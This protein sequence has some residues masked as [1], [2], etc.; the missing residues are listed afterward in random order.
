MSYFVFLYSNKYE[1]CMRHVVTKILNIFNNVTCARKI[2][3]EMII[4]ILY[5]KRIKPLVNYY[6]H[7]QLLEVEDGRK[8][9]QIG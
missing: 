3:S 2:I 1:F 7:V 9:I 8:D 5:G 6:V 4:Y